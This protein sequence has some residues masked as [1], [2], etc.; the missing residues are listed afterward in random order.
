[1]EPAPSLGEGEQ[2][3]HAQICNFVAARDLSISDFIQIA[4]QQVIKAEEAKLV[5]RQAENH[6]WWK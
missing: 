5:L 4:A 2:S 1:M 3:L 6:F